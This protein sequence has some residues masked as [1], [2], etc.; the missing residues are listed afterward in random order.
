MLDDVQIK[1]SISENNILWYKILKK[2]LNNL[3][4]FIENIDFENL[5][6]RCQFKDFKG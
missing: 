5:S 4:F 1:C 2:S 6:K 3:P